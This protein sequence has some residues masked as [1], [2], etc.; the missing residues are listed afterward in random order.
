MQPKTAAGRNPRKISVTKLN[1]NASLEDKLTH[2]SLLLNYQFDE[3]VDFQRR[4]IRLVGD[5]DEDMFKLLDAAMSCM[6][7]ESKSSITIKINSHG[8]YIYQA[9]AIVGRIR[10]SKCKIVTKGYGPIMS[11][12]TLILAS[13]DR[14][15]ISKHS[16]FMHH[17]MSY[18][19]QGR[20]SELK[21]AVT[22]SEREEVQWAG[23]MEEFSGRPKDFWLKTGVGI[24]IYF[25]AEQL[26]ETGVV[27]ELF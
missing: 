13:G 16:W 22:Q 10:E 18:G 24:D 9:M 26:L 2:A 8:G 14:R 19:L 25:T 17:E 4:E 27:D 3:G 6:E 1:P 5:V 23:W 11:A 15:M 20:H 7:T 21:A 12:A